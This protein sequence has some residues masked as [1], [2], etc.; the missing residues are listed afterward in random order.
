MFTI[1][2]AYPVIRFSFS[3]P[4]FVG[5]HALLK[6]L[7]ADGSSL[8]HGPATWVLENNRYITLYNLY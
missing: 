4:G 1:L 3:K 2:L 8:N 6:T 5:T 7:P